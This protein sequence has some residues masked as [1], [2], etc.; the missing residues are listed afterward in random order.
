MTRSLGVLAASLFAASCGTPALM[1]L[2]MG[3]GAP[4]ADAGGVVAQATA[5]CRGINTITLEISVHG[6]AGGHKLRGRLTAGLATPASARLEANA[7]FGQPIFIF[8]ARRDGN[9]GDASLLLPRDRRVLEHGNPADL[10]EA[11]SGVPLDA[12]SLRTLITGC[13]N[14]PD[15]SDAVAFGDGWRVAPDGPDNVY[16]HRDS[17]SGPWRLVATVRR[18][19]WRAEYS[20]FENNLPRAI[21]IVSQPAGRF[22]LQMDLSQLEINVPLGPDAF[23]L[24]G[25]AGAAPITLEELRQSGPLGEPST[26]VP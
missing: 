4:A 14:A 18:D 1:K 6:S 13:A 20:M 10:L 11:V 21:H 7:P 5:A 24:E 17:S 22:D 19:A 9:A 25:T 16:F 3:P 8:V 12:A 2:P 23:R 15:G 26:R